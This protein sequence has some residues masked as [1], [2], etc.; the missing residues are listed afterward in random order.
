LRDWAGQ[1]GEWWNSTSN[2]VTNMATKVGKERSWEDDTLSRH[3]QYR[4]ANTSSP[5]LLLGYE[6]ILFRA[7]GYSQQNGNSVSGYQDHQRGIRNF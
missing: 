3:E 2:R 5:I 7:T 1:N 6:F 4:A